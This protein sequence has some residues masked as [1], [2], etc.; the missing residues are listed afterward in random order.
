[1]SE[2]RFHAIHRRVTQDREDSLHFTD[3]KT[4]M[5]TRQIELDRIIDISGLK[6][7]LN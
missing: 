7:M 6:L 3:K 2:H 5:K 4:R 1:M